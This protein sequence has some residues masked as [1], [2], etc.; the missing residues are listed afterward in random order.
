MNFPKSSKS[1]S[2]TMTVRGMSLCA[3]A[4]PG[5][6]RT[7]LHIIEGQWAEKSG[8][9]CLTPIGHENAGWVQEGAQRSATLLG[10]YR[11]HA[12]ADHLWFLSRVPG[13][14]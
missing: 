8:G 11:D 7:D 12:P 14:R 9:S 6:A 5:C 4:A 1:L 13:R 2:P 3:L 10:R